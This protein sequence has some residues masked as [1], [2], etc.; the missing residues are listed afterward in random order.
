VSRPPSSPCL[1]RRQFRPVVQMR[2]SCQHEDAAKA[3]RADQML[4]DE[5]DRDYLPMGAGEDLRIPRPG[6]GV[7]VPVGSSPESPAG[8][9]QGW[10]MAPAAFHRRRAGWAG[11]PVRVPGDPVAS[12]GSLPAARPE[13]GEEE[14]HLHV[15]PG[16]G[17]GQKMERLEDEHRWSDCVDR[18]SSTDERRAT[19]SAELVQPGGGTSR[20]PIRS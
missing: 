3:V 19:S 13:S 14:R 1:L 5:D 2:P 12:R 17:V 8:C 20:Q 18:P 10:A 11:A 9:W 15:L 7:E 4:G 6:A 16:R